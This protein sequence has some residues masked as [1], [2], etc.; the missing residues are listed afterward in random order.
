M[1]AVSSIR[2]DADRFLAV[3]EHVVDTDTLRLLSRPDGMRLTPKAAA[4]LLQ[5]V[6]AAGRTLSRDE[7]I[8]HV[9][10]GTCPTNDVLTQAI[11]DLRR[12]L[13]DDLH[14]PRYVET[15]PRMG[16]RL[17]APAHFVEENEF[18][19]PS[20]LPTAPAVT[21][22]IE[23]PAVVAP[24]ASRAR[25]RLWIA[26]GLGLLLLVI[27]W[28]GS[29]LR[30][31]MNHAIAST[32]RWHATAKR[33]ITADPGAERSP[34][35]SPDG[36]RIA[37]TVGDVSLRESHIVQRS[38]GASRARSLNESRG[39]PELYPVWSPDG[40][41]IAY[42][43]L[44]DDHCTIVAEP[45]LGGAQRVIGPCSANSFDQ[46]SWA[47][48]ARHLLMTVSPQ[49]QGGTARTIVQVPVA[50]GSV[51]PLQ[52]ERASFDRDLDARYSP[53]GHRIAFRRG[54]NPYSDLYVMNAD[55]G[56][57]RRLTRLISRIRGF[58]WTRDG[59]AL[60]FSSGHAGE[61]ALYT[62]SIDDGHVD[63][64][65]V[66]PAEFPS[67]ARAS[68]TIVYEISRRRTQLMSIAL[69]GS[70]QSPGDVVPSTG[71]DGSPDLSPADDRLAFVSDRGGAQQL[72]L[73]D[74]AS[75]ETFALTDA[76]EPT[77]RHPVWSHDG[78][79]LLVTARGEGWGHLIEIDV[80]TRQR[81]VLTSRE[82]D[83][84]YGLYGS[85]PGR[86]YAVV[87]DAEK[88]RQLVE[89][90]SK[91][92]HAVSRRVLAQDVGRLEYD[93]VDDVLYFTRLS[94]SGL[95]RV[96]PQTGLEALVTR[97]IDPGQLEGWQVAAG[98]IF[99]IAPHAIGRS[100][101]HVFDPV[102]GV[103]SEIAALPCPLADLNFSIS[104]DRKH[105]IVVHIEA[106][107]TDIGAIT[108]KR[109]GSA[110]DQASRAG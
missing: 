61:Q 41:T 49:L 60:V 24:L 104:R 106:P 80:A 71:S 87:N 66:Q 43:R 34:R 100:D 56:S 46:F 103:E 25:T 18:A 67:S 107:D 74:P 37:Y 14:A 86:Y 42:M 54:A 28:K 58:D 110:D 30:G 90:A 105:A 12:A 96:D 7:L 89:F 45:A 73:H 79:H 5:L 47:P 13:G 17:V 108:L 88:T 2:P 22:I 85:T 70:N 20:R 38:L 16:Y 98:K 92:G 31:D 62:V 40:G 59:S 53:D 32:S 6:H 36:T 65:D 4:V 68:D 1:N 11:K 10:K 48:D 9:W 91:D 99:Y 83:V 64:L 19:L 26:A 33:L 21:S 72:W 81:T 52:Y 15:L 23:G 57:V 78:T 95:F 82:D 55:G 97:A 29:V 102:G 76:D 51:L 39:G 77:L 75:N 3:G 94:Q 44:T 27:A 63:A 69:D 8:G 84:R 101:I 35:I 109:G 50:G 93:R